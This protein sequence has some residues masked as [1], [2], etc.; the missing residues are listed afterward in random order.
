MLGGK[1]SLL[2]SFSMKIAMYVPSW[3]PGG[4]A[5]GNVTYASHMVPALRNAGHEVYI[6]T[7]EARSVDKYTIDLRTFDRRLIWHRALN[8]ISPG[9]AFFSE[10]SNKLIQAVRHLVETRGVEVIE[11]EESFGLS[12]AI[13]NL[14]LI[15]V[16]VRLHGPWFLNG[17]FAS[18][19]KQAI[20][21]SR[22]GTAIKCADLISAP[23]HYVL[24]ET[25]KRY[26]LKQ[27]NPN[28]PT[29]AYL[30]NPIEIPETR[31]RL[32]DC[33]KNSLLFVGRFDKIKGGDT[34]INAFAEVAAE[35]PSLRLTFVGPDRHVSGISCRDFID[36]FPDNIKSRITYKGALSRPEI[37]DLRGKNFIT[38]FASRIEI[39]GYTVLE[40]MAFGS[41]IVASAA[42]GAAELVKNKINGLSFAPGD[43]VG[44]AHAIGDLLDAPF[45]AEGLG[46]RARDDAE[47]YGISSAANQTLH[48]YA[49]AIERRS[50]ER[51]RRRGR[52]LL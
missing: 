34:V 43:P 46:A 50:A 14:N 1:A 52:R 15:P 16:V 36:A 19:P 38:L 23:S 42:G 49:Q 10:T 4:D 39:S 21:E 44:L 26:S 28:G 33:D 41:P 13:S 47:G 40:A 37:A 31:W 24:N 30:P 27:G 2:W 17:T 18:D 45:L 9:A 32:S 22:E 20:R 11:M 7:P 48:C 35:R 12:T 51:P 6:I 29:I 25:I 5:N 3:P 8:K